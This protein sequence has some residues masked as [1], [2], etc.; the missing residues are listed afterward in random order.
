MWTGWMKLREHQ[1]E[2]SPAPEL[3]LVWRT[4]ESGESEMRHS[5]PQHAAAGRAGRRRTERVADDPAEERDGR[6]T[7]RRELSVVGERAPL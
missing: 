7:Q 1:R 2:A 4:Q 6:T 3:I 5:I